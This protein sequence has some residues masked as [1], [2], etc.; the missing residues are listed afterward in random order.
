MF[1]YTLFLKRCGIQGSELTKAAETIWPHLEQVVDRTRQYG[2]RQFQRQLAA[3]TDANPSHQQIASMLNI[4]FEESELTGWPSAAVEP[5][6][7]RSTK[8]QMR[9]AILSTAIQAGA[10]L[11]VRGAIELV[12][13]KDDRLKCSTKTMAADLKAICDV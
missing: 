6:L 5:A 7:S 13:A 12:E 11:S 8:Q 9:R 3:A 10:E 1:L 4:T 2:R